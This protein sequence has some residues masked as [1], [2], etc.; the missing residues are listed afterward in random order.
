MNYYYIIISAE[1]QEPDRSF[2]IAHPL[3]RESGL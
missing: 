3:G 1:M 2:P